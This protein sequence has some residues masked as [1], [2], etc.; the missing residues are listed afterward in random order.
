MGNQGRKG[1]PPNQKKKPQP[2][3]ALREE[4]EGWS[5]EW[6]ALEG[7]ELQEKKGSSF[8]DKRKGDKGYSSWEKKAQG[9]A[10][11]PGEKM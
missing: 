2:K 3:H 6:P 11:F 1:D 9:G 7:G 4:R 5:W 8:P 10:L